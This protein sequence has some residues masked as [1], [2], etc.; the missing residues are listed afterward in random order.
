MAKEKFDP[1]K[2][3]VVIFDFD[4][5]IYNTD[6]WKYWETYVELM[7][8][9]ILGNK[10][11]VNDF[12]NKHGISCR[13]NGQQIATALIAE[14]GSAKEMTDYLAE[15]IYDIWD[16]THIISLN[17]EDFKVI[18]NK[19]KLYIVSN[20]ARAYVLC[21]LKKIGIDESIFEEIYQNDFENHNPTKQVVYSKIIKKEKVTPEEV[22]MIGDSYTNDIV[23]ALNLGMQGVWVND[24]NDVRATISAL[25]NL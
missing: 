5:T 7:L 15:N 1:N 12:L 6:S 22:I 10:N 17:N 11:R 21:H 24:L 8:T 16:G 23:P 4:D 14:I 18:K 19:Y 2:V 20:G 9:H 25:E 13:T 3:K